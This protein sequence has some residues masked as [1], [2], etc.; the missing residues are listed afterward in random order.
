LFFLIVCLLRG[1][2]NITDAAQESTAVKVL[3]PELH[4][5]LQAVIGSTVVGITLLCRL[6]ILVVTAV[7]LAGVAATDTLA[8]TELILAATG[9]AVLVDT[10]ILLARVA[11]TY[12]HSIT[13]GVLAA[14][15]HTVLLAPHVLRSG[16]RV[17]GFS[18]ERRLF[19]P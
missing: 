15:G 1:P 3:V 13:E 4:L 2:R 8:V 16:G 11:A 7:L 17:H 18:M 6:L 14:A 12:T 9:H 19:G 10:P 5:A